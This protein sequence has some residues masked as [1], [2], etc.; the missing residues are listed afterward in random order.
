METQSLD[1][2]VSVRYNTVVFGRL[3]SAIF[4]KFKMGHRIV[5]LTVEAFE[6]LTIALSGELDRAPPN[7]KSQ[8][9]M[10]GVDKMVSRALKLIGDHFKK[11]VSTLSWPSLAKFLDCAVD[12]VES[13]SVFHLA[14]L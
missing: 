14:L 7:S 10:V 2:T 1:L 5:P 13:A 12:E 8:G 3:G 6:A 11:Q 9:A 4:A